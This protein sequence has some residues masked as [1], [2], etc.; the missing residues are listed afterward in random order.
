MKLIVG[1]G[2][3][4]TKYQFSR[5]NVGF[6]LMDLLSE[7]YGCEF[8]RSKAFDSELSKAEVFSEKCLLV[9]PSTF[10]NLSGAP[11]SKVARYYG[12][13][14]EDVIVIHDDI[15]LPK[16]EVRYKKSGGHGGHNGI[17]SVASSLGSDKFARVKI[18]VGR[19]EEGSQI[20]M[21]D[22]VL[23]NFRK[24]ELKLFHGDIFDKVSEHLKKFLQKSS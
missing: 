19:P 22:W 18:G 5:H 1:L 8:S 3:P 16:M 9:K 24:D 20:P 10:M 21:S 4:G 14:C 15:D 23:T 12:V 11:V 13:S 6:L 2:N 17:R 7:R